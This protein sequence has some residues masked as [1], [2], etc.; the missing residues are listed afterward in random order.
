MMVEE[1]KI[2]VVAAVA[3]KKNSKASDEART[4]TASGRLFLLTLGSKRAFS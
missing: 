2:A 3:V 1:E 4:K